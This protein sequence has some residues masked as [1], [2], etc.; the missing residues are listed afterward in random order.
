MPQHSFQPVLS[1]SGNIDGQRWTSIYYCHG[2][3]GKQVLSEMNYNLTHA[4][5][6]HHVLP[7][8]TPDSSFRQ[9]ATTGG[10]FKFFITSI[11][12]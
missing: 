7:N 10:L 5:F 1:R 11:L 8:M 3:S 4:A 6:F 9:Q 12:L 2:S